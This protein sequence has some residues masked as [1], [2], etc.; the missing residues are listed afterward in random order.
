MF[1]KIHN[2]PYHYET[3]NRLGV[4]FKRN[5][6]KPKSQF[7]FSIFTKSKNTMVKVHQSFKRMCRLRFLYPA[8]LSEKFR[9]K[10]ERGNKDIINIYR[11][12]HRG[13]A[14]AIQERCVGC[15]IQPRRI[16]KGNPRLTALWNQSDWPELENNVGEGR[17]GH[18]WNGGRFQKEKEK[19]SKH[20]NN[21]STLLSCEINNIYSHRKWNLL[22]GFSR[23][24]LHQNLV[25]F[26]L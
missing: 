25:D 3:S 18:L 19:S 20:S 24:N 23:I 15:N 16:I 26:H 4:T 8:K 5:R 9:I 13:Y 1:K 17:G 21:H 10:Y 11:E 2:W 7:S 6:I 22:H 12:V 14:C